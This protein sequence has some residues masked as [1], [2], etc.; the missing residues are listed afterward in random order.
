MGVMIILKLL[1]VPTLIAAITLAGR[2]WGPAVAG[3]LAAFPVVSAP[4]LLFM[5]LEQ[6]PAFA[7][8]AAVGTLTAVLAI[9]VFGMA[10]AWVATRHAWPFSLAA[11][12]GAYA[13]AVT[14]LSHITPSLIVVAPIVLATLAVAPRLYPSTPFFA[15]ASASAPARPAN[16]IALRMLAGAVL[17]MS[18]T[19]FAAQMGPRLSGLLAMFPVMASVL[20]VFSHRD[21]GAAFAIRLM[22]GMVLGYYAFGTFCIVLTMAL[23]SMGVA[24]SFILALGAAVAVQALSHFAL[25]PLRHAATPHPAHPKPIW[26][27]SK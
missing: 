20:A 18:V 2:R 19:H 1:M 11:G 5:A 26:S 17:V 21:A 27:P 3:W 15:P 7:E 22:R 16:D 23:R 14:G 6:G 10:Y 12:F 9:L 4:I 24:T 8:S 25:G 13:L